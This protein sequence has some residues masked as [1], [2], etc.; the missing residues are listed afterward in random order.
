VAGCGAD[1]APYFR[2]FNPSTQAAKF[3]PEE[4]YICRWAPELGSASYPPPVVDHGEARR[5]AL[6]A[7]A[8]LK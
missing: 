7:L 8:S 4:S 5:H 2:I 3:D 6:D 1:A